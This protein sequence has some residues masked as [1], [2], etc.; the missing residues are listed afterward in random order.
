MQARINQL[1][2]K[3]KDAE[4]LWTS[5]DIFNGTAFLSRVRST[6]FTGSPWHERIDHLPG[7]R[8]RR[9]KQGEL[10]TLRAVVRQLGEPRLGQPDAETLAALEAI[11]DVTRLRDLVNAAVTAAS[12]QDLLGTGTPPP[13][14]RGRRTSG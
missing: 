2:I 3:K 11:A 12:W 5:T 8:R 10:R 7:H 4:T 14:R 9:T 6:T 13:R 1:R